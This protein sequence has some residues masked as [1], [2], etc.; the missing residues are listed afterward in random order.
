MKQVILAS[1]STLL[2][3]AGL[4]WAQV[5]PAGW[6][7]GGYYAPVPAS[8]PYMPPS[9]WSGPQANMARPVSMTFDSEDM[10]PDSRVIAAQ[11]AEPNAFDPNPP[12]NDPPPVNVAAEV[13]RSP[14]SFPVPGSDSG[15]Q[16][17][18]YY[19]LD[20]DLL[21]WRVREALVIEPL[22]TTGP[23][24]GLGKLGQ[25]GT[26]ILYGHQG[27][28]YGLL[29]GV[30]V[31]LGGWLDDGQVLSLEA[32]AFTLE[33]RS[34]GY[35]RNNTVGTGVLA[36]PIVNSL[37]GLETA[38]IVGFPGSAEF[39]FRFPGSIVSSSSNRFWGAE[40]NATANVWT[41]GFRADILGGFRYLNLY[42][43]L[44]I[45]QTTLTPAGTLVRFNHNLFL[46]PTNLTTVDMFAARN[47]YFGGYLGGQVEW[48]WGCVF[49]QLAGQFGVG[50]TYQVL[51]VKGVS[52]L[53]HPGD[54]GRV[55]GAPGGVLVLSSNSDTADAGEWT[56]VPEAKARIGLNLTDAIT[57]H[58]TYNFIYWSNIIRPGYQI[59]REVNPT[60][61]PTSD[62][63]RAP[64][65]TPF[66][67]MF[68]RQT[69]F[70]AMGL[71]AGLEFR[72]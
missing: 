12:A 5:P 55:S 29:N 49:A 45:A 34:V 58:F 60:L 18:R 15:A 21:F 66:P 27:L 11:L 65:G 38:E 64:F 6:P 67:Q 69:D 25:P 47:Q 56:V 41:Y 14:D 72:F 17:P 7:T 3:G 31:A 33:T 68:L 71:A 2:A 19:W 32:S 40:L 26:F 61:L 9:A 4:A 30:N 54:V 13:P 70:W 57:F 48:Q 63:Y 1:M 37:I 62:K 23:P 35:N 44:D 16:P 59:S 24:E 42:E 46:G 43:D 8:T 50:R 52:T 22:V 53:D 10:Q 51:N 36:R 39:P 20:V 28:D